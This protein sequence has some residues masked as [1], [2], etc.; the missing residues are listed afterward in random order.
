M[1]KEHP[2]KV[3]STTDDDEE[4]LDM[5]EFDE[6]LAPN[7][8]I[9]STTDSNKDSKATKDKDISIREDVLK[10]AQKHVGTKYLYGGKDPKGFDCSGFTY[11]VLRKFDIPV[12]RT[13]RSQELNG[14]S[15]RLKEV[16]AGDLVFFRRSPIGSVFHVALVKSNT[17]EGLEVIHSTSRGV[18]VENI[19]RSSYWK[20]KLSSARTVIAK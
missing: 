7:E 3:T 20:P 13:S 5:I 1:N 15:I 10:F 4:D 8:E 19:S 18:V 9:S 17:R 12:D 2:D 16:Q 11:Y 6:E 14:K